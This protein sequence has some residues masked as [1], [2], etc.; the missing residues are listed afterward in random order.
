[1]TRR[2]IFSIE[3]ERSMKN[4]VISDP[5]KVKDIEWQIA[6]W[7][8]LEHKRIVNV[9]VESNLEDAILLWALFNLDI[10]VKLGNKTVATV[11]GR[12][13][14]NPACSEFTPVEIGENITGKD[15]TVE[16][17]MEVIR[18]K[19]FDLREPCDDLGNI[20]MDLQESTIYV[21]RAILA[22][23]SD[24]FK[25]MFGSNSFVEGQTMS[26]HLV[27]IELKDMRLLLARMY[28]I[29]IGI[30]ELQK[31]NMLPAVLE[32][33]HR[34]QCD[35]LLWEIELYLISLPYPEMS[36]WFIESDRLNF[37]RLR[38][39]ILENMS[40]QELRMYYRKGARKNGTRISNFYSVETMEKMMERW[41]TLTSAPIHSPMQMSR[42]RKAV[43]FE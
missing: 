27:D 23:H 40:L 43:R 29:P 35:M 25:V 5:K 7:R 33:A 26:C 31:E 20:K 41:N 10:T 13:S 22:A 34:F 14:H 6:S 16:A 17:M 42:K 38:E 32:L 30:K 4:K 1:M 8:D 24:Y 37:S 19:V 28:G 39:S 3:L 9:M 36:D 21:S 12:F 11:S 15:L 18:M 2:E